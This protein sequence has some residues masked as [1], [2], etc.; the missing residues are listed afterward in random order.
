MKKDFKRS[1]M[2]MKGKLAVLIACIGVFCGIL[3]AQAHGRMAQGQGKKGFQQEMGELA[4]AGRE[5]GNYICSVAEA[6]V[7][8]AEGEDSTG[9]PKEHTESPQDSVP[10]EAKA[11]SSIRITNRE[12]ALPIMD[13]NIGLL[14]ERLNEWAAEM[15]LKAST[16]EI[17]HV[18]VPQSDP[19][20]IQFYIRLDD[21]K[22]TKAMLA[23]HPREN[24]VTASSCQYSE[25]EILGEVW[26]D[27]G[28]D[29]RDA[30]EPEDGKGGGE[31]VGIE[32]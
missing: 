11:A 28:P 15:N 8:L 20:S 21:K 4:G 9:S 27:N 29:I 2:G 10:T 7:D 25:A 1:R 18:M 23:Y 24:V 5:M 30:K 17:F 19:Q 32:G 16:A 6:G 12:K 13:K 22:Q 14:E 31:P 26:E 3:A